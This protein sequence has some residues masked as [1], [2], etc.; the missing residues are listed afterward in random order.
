MLYTLYKMCS[1]HI[2]RAFRYRC[3]NVHD[4]Y[5]FLIKV[6]IIMA[7]QTY[8]QNYVQTV[9]RV[10]FSKLLFKSR[11]NVYSFVLYV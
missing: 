2:W 8:Y 4:I 1:V 6:H 5:I 7:N 9:H 11:A 3:M 10:Y